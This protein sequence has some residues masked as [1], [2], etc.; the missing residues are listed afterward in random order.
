MK[1]RACISLAALTIAA[2]SLVVPASAA[3]NKPAKAAAKG[4]AA[5]AGV[6]QLG[7]KVAMAPKE[8]QFGMSLEQVA[9]VYDRLFDREFL[10]L[11]KKAEPGS[12]MAALDAELKDKKAL[13]RRNKIEF[14]DDPTGVDYSALKGEYSYGNGES[15]TKV[16]QRSG[17]PRNFFFFSDKLWKV[18]DEHKLGKGSLGENFQQA[19]ENLSKKFGAPPKLLDADPSKGRNYAEAQWQD[20]T[21][22]IRAINREFEKTLGVVYVDRAYHDNLAKYRTAKAKNPHELDREVKSVTAN[23]P[24]DFTKE[25]PSD[26]DK[27]GKDKAK[28]KK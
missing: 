12:Q 1:F 7:K 13:V 18:Y 27:K 24:E 2:A 3:D 11:Y 4:K 9:K 26:K 28:P 10:P 14:G 23:P 19:V 21:L 22:V 5:K 17:T 16:T 20:A 15:M 25:K 6:G 8:L